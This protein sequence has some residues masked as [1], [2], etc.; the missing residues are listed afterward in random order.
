MQG[1]GQVFGY[2]TS[3]FSTGTSIRPRTRG[4]E[5]T[6]LSV[7]NEQNR[8]KLQKLVDV[9]DN[10]AIRLACNRHNGMVDTWKQSVELLNGFCLRNKLVR[11]NGLESPGSIPLE[12]QMDESKPWMIRDLALV[13]E[14][15]W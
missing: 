1:P 4:C 6:A 11:G 9:F 15:N 2:K 10:A 13:G 12:W 7:S 8:D 5:D 14:D 3:F